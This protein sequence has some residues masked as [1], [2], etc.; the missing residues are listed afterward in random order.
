MRDRNP[1]NQA[2]RSPAAPAGGPMPSSFDA[3][4]MPAAEARLLGVI[5]RALKQEQANRDAV[6]APPLVS[7][8]ETIL[9]KRLEAANDVEATPL[10]PPPAASPEVAPP[11]QAVAK[12]GRVKPL[13]VAGLMCALG[14]AS[15][16]LIPVEAA[17][18]SAEGTLAI[19]GAG[20][21]NAA[22]AKAAEKTLSS[23]HTI[24]A[25][26]AALKLDHDPEFSGASSGA[27]K[28]AVDLLSTDGSA[29]DPVSRAEVSLASAIH[30]ATDPRA[31]T[32]SLAVTTGSAEK[33][34][35]IA[36]Y[37]ASVVAGS[38]S[39]TAAADGGSL[40]NA[41]DAARLELA[42]FTQKSG[43]GN[44]KVAT[45][46]QQQI[47]GVDAELT[48]AEQ[49]IVGAQ[50][51]AARLKPTA[52]SD[53]LSGTAA[54]DLMSPTLLD[55]RDRYVAAQ[56]SLSQLSANLGPRHPRLQA[57]QAEVDGLRNAIAEDLDR[58]LR[59]ANDDVKA[60]TAEK[61][62]LNS[63]RNALIAQS[64]DTGVDLAKL[65]ELR[66]KASAARSRLEDAITTGAVPPG[67]GTVRLEKALHVAVL[68]AGQAWL[69]PLLG[70]LAGLAFGLAAISVRARA[71]LAASARK[72]PS[73]LA[74][75]P[76][77]A[78]A[79]RQ[80]EDRVNAPEDVDIIRAELAAM[81]HRLRTR[82]AAS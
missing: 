38:G 27:F 62:Q 80:A 56:L 7:R 26:V 74:S 47:A 35:R 21:D 8:I 65:T 54:A 10:E 6:V 5:E 76:V 43:E 81:R 17:L 2:F 70:A 14:A 11:T 66:D 31:G 60:V 52:V 79:S 34:T 46:L 61:R 58:M 78:A 9:G 51:K 44:V 71:T 40:K 50:D 29:A 41:D 45:D 28:V 24:A 68:P 18:Y 3:S 4:A 22:V 67:A 77:Q 33:S 30:T 72:E 23:S 19:H 73:L 13:A 36:G 16:T 12:K 55:H 59:E 69:A 42:S 82:P 20:G 1:R 39:K 75:A 49:R 37:L 64:K 15:G 53:V 32:I 57:Q 48:A 63:H 25:A